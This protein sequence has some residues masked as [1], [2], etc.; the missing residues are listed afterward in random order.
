M[1]L[2]LNIFLYSSA[3]MLSPLFPSFSVLVLHLL[4]PLPFSSL[5]KAGSCPGSGQGVRVRFCRL[6]SEPCRWASDSLAP[7]HIPSVSQTTFSSQRP[8]FSPSAAVTQRVISFVITL[9]KS[10][11]YLFYFPTPNH[12]H[13]MATV[14]EKHSH[15]ATWNLVSFTHTNM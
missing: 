14:R 13:I 4:Q 1:F 7:L 8:T 5:L 3:F 11:R 15:Q 6:R 2:L 12:S 9:H 10:R